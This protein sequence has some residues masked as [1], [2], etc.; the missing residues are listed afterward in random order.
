MRTNQEYYEKKLK[1]LRDDNPDFAK[2]IENKFPEIISEEPF[3]MN[4][5][6]F[7]KQQYDDTIYHLITVDGKFAVRTLKYNSIW[8]GR[9]KATNEHVHGQIAY[10]NKHDFNILLRDSGYSITQVRV[11][12]ISDIIDLHIKLFHRCL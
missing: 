1:Q 12:E 2:A 6:L 4:N 8:T 3:I 11:L 9:I 7:M 5:G 10:L